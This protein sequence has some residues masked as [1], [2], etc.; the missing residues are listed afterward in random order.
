MPRHELDAEKLGLG[1]DWVGNS[2][3]FTCPECRKVFLVSGLIHG[4]G[5]A[6]PACGRATAHIEGGAKSGGSAWIES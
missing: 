6:C 1:E 5:R 4:G 3:A 2:A